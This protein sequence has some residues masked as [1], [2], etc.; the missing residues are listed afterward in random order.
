MNR[1]RTPLYMACFAALAALATVV[2]ARVADPTV[3]PV[4]LASVVAATLA[5]APGLVRPRAWPVALL[6]LPIGAYLL[7]RAQ[8]PPPPEFVGAGGHLAFYAGEAEAGAAAYARDVFP[9]DVAGKDDLR[10]LLSL[11]VY[12]WIWVAAFVALSLRR[13][14][15]GI[16]MLLILAGFGF[17]VDGTTGDLWAALAFV[18]L[19]GGVLV[20]SRAVRLRRL[21]AAEAVVGGVTVVLAT[22]FALSFMGAT[23]VE[24]GK[25][26]QDW[27]EWDLG[28]SA[29]SALRFNFMQNY[30]RLLDPGNDEPVMRVHS[31][32]SSY[33][34]ANVLD[35]FSG[36]S[37]R[38]SLPDGS[39]LRAGVSGGMWTYDIPTPETLPPGRLV[40]QRFEIQRTAVDRLFAGGWAMQVRTR[41]PL[42]LRA[43]DSSAI[44]IASAGGSSLEY[45][46]D[47][48]VP[49]L[50]PADLLGRGRVYP[51]DVA[52]KYLSLPFPA[53]DVDGRRLSQGEWRTA[54]VSAPA[55]RE[56]ADLY[57]LNERI[58][59]EETD[60][61]RVALAM[62][63]YL[64]SSSLYTLRPPATH[65]DS[66]YAAFLF[67]TR[68][69]YCQH[70]AGAMAAILRFN[71]IPA[72]VV[73][74]FTS[75]TEEQS[76]V[77]AVSSNDAH[78]WVEAYFPG[79]GW[80]P[81]DPTPGRSLPSSD[82][83]PT[84]GPDAAAAAGLARGS[85]PPPP[86]D[87]EDTGEARVADPGGPGENAATGTS[88]TGPEGGRPWLLTLLAIPLAWPAYRAV[89]RRLRLRRGSPE[90]RLEV[91]VALLYAD[92]RACG[93]QVAP[94]QTLDETADHLRRRLDVDAGDLPDRVQAVA[95]GG[96]PATE[97]DLQDLT[98]LRRRIRRRLRE[99]SGRTA[100]LFASLGVPPRGGRG[101][102]LGEA[103]LSPRS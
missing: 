34:R 38:R 14:L 63:H 28:V 96:R 41:E 62:E 23:A 15:P 21:R 64:R 57:E 19:A 72:R 55:G 22:T 3:V 29:S 48:V 7:S 58:V 33:W 66:P 31:P 49:D 94:S 79:S 47:A 70:F 26:L 69:G 77:W 60:P 32:V 74:G 24:A 92:L 59:G 36:T 97:A 46:V 9:L 80:A 1:L 103:R 11:V 75:G 91:A 99:R 98:V 78:A 4:L 25:P 44:A 2:A 39:E 53:R 20:V 12:G 101:R 61:Y 42:T 100:S 65:H 81:F 45:T 5:G 17:T 10:L 52:G 71:G 27:R 85:A 6:L 40:T 84:S 86:G 83:P 13:P 88:F 30:P 90:Q 89:S 43:A 67:A 93:V 35:E 16:V 50:A 95:F 51:A 18:A 56:W 76:G 8:I 102:R 82:S 68:Q 87:E 54:A 37:W 73:V